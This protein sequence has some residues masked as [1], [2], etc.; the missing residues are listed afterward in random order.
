MDYKKRI[1]LITSINY[2]REHGEPLNDEE[3]DFVIETYKSLCPLDYEL[4]CFM[5]ALF[6]AGIVWIVWRVIR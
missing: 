2:K 5:F 3:M 4:T 1:E 6:I